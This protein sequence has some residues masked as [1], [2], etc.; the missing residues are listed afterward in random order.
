MPLV[1]GLNAASARGSVHGESFQNRPRIDQCCSST[2]AKLN[3]PL[4]A[5]IVGA[6][7]EKK[8][9]TQKQTFVDVARELDL[10]CGGLGLPKKELK[11]PKS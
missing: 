4:E 8:H 2:G 3:M 1:T 7:K 9:G 11:W 10:V 6:L 5:E